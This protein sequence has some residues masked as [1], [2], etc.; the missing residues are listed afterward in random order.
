MN[1]RYYL[2]GIGRFVSADTI[3]PDREDPQSFNRYSYARNNPINLV[4]PDGHCWGPASFIRGWNVDTP[5]GTVG[6]GTN[7]NNIDMALAIVQHPEATAADKVWPSLYLGVSGA[8]VTTGAAGAGLLACSAVAT[9]T[10]AART[11]AGV[12]TTTCSDGDCTNDAQVVTKVM[13]HAVDWLSSQTNRIN[14]I[15]NPQAGGNYRP[16]HDWSQLINY[17][18]DLAQ[19]YRALQPYLNAVIQH[20]VQTT[21]QHGQTVYAAT[22]NRVPIEVIGRIVKG[23][24]TI[25]DA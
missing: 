4:D 1:A 2:P 21:G 12:G 16:G 17:T 5:W 3:V 15:M 13:R 22:V 9:C 7:C 14:H 23:V 8:T 6:G 25:T 24:F 10:A 11:V 19:D 20:G 18:D